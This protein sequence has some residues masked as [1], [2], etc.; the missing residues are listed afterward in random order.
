MP[1]ALVLYFTHIK[2][3]LYDRL[4][5]RKH[6]T[7]DKFKCITG[8]LHLIKGALRGIGEL[9]AASI[10]MGLGLLFILLVPIILIYTDGIYGDGELVDETVQSVS[11]EITEE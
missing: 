8:P 3:G 11:E 7:E 9:F 2:Q 6:G 4:Y 10:W 5:A 1:I